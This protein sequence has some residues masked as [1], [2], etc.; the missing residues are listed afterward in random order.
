M[1][2]AP[3]TGNHRDFS[4]VCARVRPCGRDMDRLADL[5][6]TSKKVTLLC[7]IGYAG[8]HD[9]VMKLAEILKAPVVHTLRGKDQ[10]QFD[11][12]YDVGMTGLIG[13]ASGYLA[14]ETC[15]L[16]LMLGTDFPYDNFYPGKAKIAQI[17]VRPEHH[18]AISYA[19]DA[20]RIST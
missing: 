19:S 18:G 15:D 16:P 1:Q 12:P 3:D 8:A 10:L 9:Q 2:E 4:A 11:N 13:H 5:L 20:A 17:D 7:G 14:T 6:N